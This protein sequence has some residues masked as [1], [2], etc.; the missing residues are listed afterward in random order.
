MHDST[1]M[2]YRDAFDEWPDVDYIKI[3][4]VSHDPVT[5]AIAVQYEETLQ[6][7]YIIEF[8]QDCGF[9]ESTRWWEGTWQDE[10]F[11]IPPLEAS[12]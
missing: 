9:L 10:P 5:G 12:D 7:N 6:H 3:A 8:W 1:V 4:A 2:K 11:Q